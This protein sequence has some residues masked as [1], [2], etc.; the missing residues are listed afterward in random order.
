M[1]AMHAPEIIS[2]RSALDI[3]HD[4]IEREKWAD[5]PKEAFTYYSSFHLVSADLMPS[6]IN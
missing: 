6:E 1:V 3:T 2:N 5:T 4:M